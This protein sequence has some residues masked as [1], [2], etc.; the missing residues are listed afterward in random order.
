MASGRRDGIPDPI[1]PWILPGRSHD[2]RWGDI[3]EFC[4]GVNTSILCDNDSADARPH[5]GHITPT[6]QFIDPKSDYGFKYLFGTEPRKEFLISLLQ[7]IF[8][9]RLEINDIVY[10][11][12]EHLNNSRH[13]R[14]ARFDI[15][16]TS[17]KGDEFIIEM[18]QASQTYFKDRADYYTGLVS[19]HC[20]KTGNWNYKLPGIHFV[21]I[22]G[23]MLDDSPKK[24]VFTT[25]A[26]YDFPVYDVSSHKQIKA[27]LQLPEFGLEPSE[28]KTDLHRWMYLLKHLGTLKKIPVFSHSQVFKRFLDIA[29][30]STLPKN[31]RDMYKKSLE[32]KRSEFASLE[33]ARERGKAEG[34]A[35][36]L[37]EGEA[38]GLAEGKAKG[39][40]EGKAKGLAEGKAKGL[41]E[42]KAKER[43]IIKRLLVSNTLSVSEISK[44]LEM[45]PETVEEINASL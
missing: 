4:D 35:E 20:A 36:G 14:S 22:M 27:F 13:A 5:V 16:C 26:R 29:D 33:T 43:A 45:D 28:L 7:N 3:P 38:K 10:Q 15:R 25:S 34:K 21:G 18:Q 19:S 11:N 6:V 31:D 32:Q 23:F 1:K 2:S 44:V 12:T 24:D 8:K 42:G 30:I 17:D 40:A 37:A 41:A 39:L 9:K